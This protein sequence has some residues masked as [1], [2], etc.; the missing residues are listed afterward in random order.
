MIGYAVSQSTSSPNISCD[1][2]S[3]FSSFLSSN[4]DRY[5][6]VKHG[7]GGEDF[8]T[9]LGLD[10]C[11]QLDEVDISSQIDGNYAEGESAARTLL[12]EQHSDLDCP[13]C[14]KMHQGGEES[15]ALV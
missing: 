2:T 14:S 11:T 15:A 7:D 1:D 8:R 4:R 5:T 13:T 9:T 10:Y 3:R 6:S 12:F